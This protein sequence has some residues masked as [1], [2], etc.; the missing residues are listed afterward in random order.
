MEP[1]ALFPHVRCPWAQV[2]FFVPARDSDVKGLPLAKIME[3]RHPPLRVVVMVFSAGRSSSPA[4]E[5]GLSCEPNR[6][7][8]RQQLK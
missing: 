5:G 3:G 2:L 6:Y 7:R 4:V 1:P 8:N